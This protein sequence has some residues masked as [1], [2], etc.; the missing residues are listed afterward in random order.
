[1]LS[2][3]GAEVKNER[4]FECGA[5]F[6]CVVESTAFVDKSLLIFEFLLTAPKSVLTTAPRCFGKSTNID[7]LKRFFE[8]EVDE[9][10]NPKT[11]ANYTRDPVTD[12]GNYDMFVRNELAITKHA[13]TM[14][15]HF[16][17]H[18]VITVQF[19]CDKVSN[20]FS[21]NYTV[22]CCKHVIHKAF[23]QHKYLLQSKKLRDEEKRTFKKWCEYPSYMHSNESDI[24]GALNVLSGYLY[25]HF[26]RRTVFVLVDDYDALI[27]R[28]M[29]KVEDENELRRIIKF[30][31]GVLEDVL[32]K[33][34]DTVVEQGLITGASYIA[35]VNWYKFSNVITCRFLERHQFIDFYGV[36]RGEINK[37]FT[38][39]EFTADL[40]VEDARQ[41]ACDGHT[42]QTGRRIYSLYSLLV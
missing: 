1:M 16:G 5:E 12:T 26:K 32:E 28:A 27:T 3:H 6:S 15:D 31:I 35:S 40:N 2:V 38:K 22:D 24:L 10:G 33:Y 8:I 14:E 37:L 20:A 41:L 9:S 30:N 42:S 29:F 7:M 21:Y 34:N 19:K 39:P 4:Q 25:T 11:K 13:S 36:T 18:P 23:L 17:R